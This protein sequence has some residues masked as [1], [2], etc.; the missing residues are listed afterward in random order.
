MSRTTSSVP[1]REALDLQARPLPGPGGDPIRNPKVLPTGKNIHALDPQA[2]PTGAAVAS[3][4]VVV[5]RLIERQRVENNGVYPESIALVLWGTDNIKTYGESLAQVMLMV[6]VNPVPDALGRVNK[7]E[8][9]PL[10]EL[11]RPRI[12]VVVNCSGVFRDLFVNQ[13]NLLIAAKLAAEQD[14]P[15]EMNF[16]RKHALEQAEELGMSV[17][18]AATRIFSNASGSYSSNVNLAVENSS[19]NDESQLQDM[20][21]NRKLFAFNSD[22]PGSGMEIKREIFESSLFKVDVT[23]QNLDSSEISDGRFPLLSI[24]I[25]PS[26][27]PVEKKTVKCRLPSSPI[28]PLPMRKSDRCPK[29][30]AWT[31]ERSC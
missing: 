31:L 28:R 23:F 21:L 8:L 27:L 4:K 24:P 26:W 19:R 18:E 13:M 10:E 2:I 22:S 14:E 9:I 1:W 29:P 15:P 20:Y 30:C 5:D 17:R 7:L 11:G 16:V 12:D 3:A 6:G 25:R